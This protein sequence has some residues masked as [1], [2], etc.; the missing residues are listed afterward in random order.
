MAAAHPED[1]YHRRALDAKKREQK[2]KRIRPKRPE[3]D[4]TEESYS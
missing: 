2:Q 4:E 1:R 3:A